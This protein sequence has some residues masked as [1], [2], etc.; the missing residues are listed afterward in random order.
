MYVI[1]MNGHIILVDTCTENNL[2]ISI[3]NIQFLLTLH[4]YP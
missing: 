4:I 2:S 1:Y 3:S